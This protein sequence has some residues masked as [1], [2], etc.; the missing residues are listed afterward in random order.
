MDYDKLKGR[1]IAQVTTQ[2][3]DSEKYIEIMITFRDGTSLR[4]KTVSAV[5]E[6]FV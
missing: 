3:L 5:V 4:I 2:V 1:T 6:F